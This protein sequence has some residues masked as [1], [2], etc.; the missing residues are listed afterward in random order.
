MLAASMSA[1]SACS[2]EPAKPNVT[3]TWMNIN[4]MCINTGIMKM[5][6]TADNYI[7][8]DVRDPAAMYLGMYGRLQKA[9]TCTDIKTTTT[10]LQGTFTLTGPH[11]VITRPDAQGQ[12]SAAPP[13]YLKVN[14]NTLVTA[15]DPNYQNDVATFK[16]V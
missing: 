12:M 7:Q 1:L 8:A 6:L 14:G 4:Q 2:T 15:S 11:F 10:P 5:N 9:A 3:G 13:L 16:R